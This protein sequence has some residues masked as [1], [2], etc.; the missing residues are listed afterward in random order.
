MGRIRAN[1]RIARCVLATGFALLLMTAIAPGIDAAAEDT[2]SGLR[3]LGRLQQPKEAHDPL[4]ESTAKIVAVDAQARRLYYLY[5]RADGSSFVR[6]YDLDS[7]VPRYVREAPVLDAAQFKSVAMIS[8]KT[9]ALDTRR[10]RLL[11]AH[12]TG[13]PPSIVRIELIDLKTL[14]WVGA[15]D[16]TLQAP[17]AQYYGITYSSEDDRLYLV[18]EGQPVYGVGVRDS[19]FQSVIPAT[20]TVVAA[21]EAE[22]GRLAWRHDVP[23]CQIPMANRLAGAMIARS[24]RQPVL[25]FGCV[26]PFVYP[27]ES[28]IFRLWITP[29][30]S[31][32]DA[33]T[34]RS[35][36]FP[37]SGSYT[38]DGV[39]GNAVFDFETDR[40]FMQSV[41][42]KTPGAW[43]FDGGKSAWAGFI[44]APNDR[45]FW[46]GFNSGRGR[47]YSGTAPDSQPGYI[48]A[49]DGRSTPVPQGRVLQID[50]EI[51]SEIF[52]DP[53]SKRL[54]V[55]VHPLKGKVTGQEILVFEDTADLPLP[56]PPTDFDT[57]TLDI[58]EGPG[59]ASTFAGGV[60]GFGVHALLVGGTGGIESQCQGSD[61]AAAACT[62]LKEAVLGALGLSLAPADRALYA[63]R[64]A[65]LD[66]RNVGASASANALDLDPVTDGEYVTKIQEPTAQRVEDSTGNKEA[67]ASVESLLTWPHAAATC[68]DGGGN[69]HAEEKS[70]TGGGSTVSC[71]LSKLEASTST[72]FTAV[73]VAG[74]SVAHSSFSSRVRRDLVA[75]TVTETTAIAKG[76]HLASPDGG[77]ASIGEVVAQASTVAH[78]RPR[79]ASAQW[80]RTISNVVV[81][82]ASGQATFKCDDA[83]SCDPRAVVAAINQ[84][85]GIRMRVYLPEAEEIATPKGAF[86]TVRKSDDDFLNSS[87][88]NND[89]SRAVPALEIVVFNDSVERSRLLI[90]LAG[91]EAS[92]IYGISALPD[93][94][95]FEPPGP[96][97][98]PPL[99]PLPDVLPPT[100]GPPVGGIVA[101]PRSPGAKLL[102]AA[103]F[104]F[105]SPK[106][107]LLVGLI[108]M[109]FIGAGTV[110]ARRRTLLRQLG[111]GT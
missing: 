58:A 69:P 68:L 73:S 29:D 43:V 11:I 63:S 48:L 12:L 1:G 52:T 90:Q 44:S 26:R 50:D 33:L 87:T 41:S 83:D 100:V 79:T 60:N 71:D 75:G 36:L 53:L 15:F 17:G 74:V 103:L 89:A 108:A 45:V 8:P 102:S 4:L 111:G 32:V 5:G 57:L 39:Q 66:V 20:L 61:Q 3:L 76:I 72:T 101:P 88:V 6:E 97:I 77:S 40:F 23:Q 9:I 25:Y 2:E 46:T 94:S 65:A 92:S 59:T 85:L 19:N 104:L 21:L 107:A 35:E 96:G 70:G 13:D 34:F 84:A 49:S 55:Q 16:L 110:A 14:K 24:H 30:A 42:L 95:V 31:P 51:R 28:G 99:P 109:L 37:V 80:T 93:S 7:P 86:A 62:Q 18:G 82:N 54:F 105:R 64:V 47:Y 38:G 91:I 67:A 27:G 106:D 56:P 22:T 10:R 98:I 78:G 81:R